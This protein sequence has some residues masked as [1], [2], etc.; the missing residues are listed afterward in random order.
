MLTQQK[1]FFIWKLY[2]FLFSEK[3]VKMIM[4]V[5]ELFLHC[6]MYLSHGIGILSPVMAF[7]H[8]CVFL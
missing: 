7:N 3:L 1:I 4:L 6:V 5:V 2:L 8:C